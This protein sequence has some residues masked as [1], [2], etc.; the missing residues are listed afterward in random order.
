[1]YRFDSLGRFVEEDAIFSDSPVD[2]SGFTPPKG[3]T[4]VPPPATK[5]GEVAVWE[6]GAW[7]VA[8]LS[9]FE[10]PQPSLDELKAIREAEMDALWA[11]KM[12]EG[13]ET[14][15]G[16]K[17]KIEPLDLSM[18]DRAYSKIVSTNAPT[19]PLM[20]DFYG[21]VHRDVPAQTVLTICAEANAYVEELWTHKVL[22][23]EMIRNAT[24]IEA[25]NQITWDT[26]TS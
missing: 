17:I 23:Q 20:R 11:E 4:F 19:L 14:T 7:R 25:L 10:P 12:T 8:Q 24:S 16:Y 13:L 18:W 5:E 1:M 6:N 15:T 9:E 21:E 2:L 26:P 3:H 22:L